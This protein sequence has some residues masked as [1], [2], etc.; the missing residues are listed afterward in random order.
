VSPVFL[1]RGEK[2]FDGIDLPAL[3]FDVTEKVNSGSAMH[4]VLT[5]N[6]GEAK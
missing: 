5:K 2:M 1:G 3:G 6:S 4:V